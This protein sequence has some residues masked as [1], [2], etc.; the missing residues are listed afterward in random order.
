MFKREKKPSFSFA[1]RFQLEKGQQRAAA[2]HKAAANNRESKK[3]HGHELRDRFV[4]KI[5]I[6]MKNGDTDDKC[7]LD[8]STHVCM[9]EIFRSLSL[10][11]RSYCRTSQT[12]A[13]P[14]H[15]L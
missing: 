11:Y 10:S 3:E 9:A 8:E 6:R 14:I 13:Q 5:K 7:T 4:Q 15:E 1:W 12:A 2:Q